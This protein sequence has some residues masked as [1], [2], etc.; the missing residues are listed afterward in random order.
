MKLTASPGMSFT[1]WELRYARFSSLSTLALFFYFDVKRSVK[2][3]FDKL[4]AE[5]IGS[6]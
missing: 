3:A 6:K 5:T 2:Y 4:R 1:L